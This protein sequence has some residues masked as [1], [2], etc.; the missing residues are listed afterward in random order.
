VTPA[1]LVVRG[2]PVWTGGEAWAEALAIREGTLT[3]VG[4]RDEVAAHLGPDTRVIDLPSD[5]LVLPGFIDAHTH[6][7]TGPLEAAGIDLTEADTLDEVRGILENADRSS[8]VIGGGWRSHIFPDGPDRSLLDEIF[9]TTPVLL[10]EINSHSLWVNSAALAGAG[11]TAA[12]PDPEPGFSMFVHDERGE[13]TGWVL[14]QTAMDLIRN[15]VDPPSPGR[16]REALLAIQREYAA[17]GLTAAFDAGIFMIGERD[18]WE[19]LA[20]L[21]RH[22]LLGQRVVGSKVA[23]IDPDGAVAI[24]AA[25]SAEV[26]SANVRIDT[27]KIFVDGVPE[28]HTAAY[29]E[30]Y[31]DRP[32]TAGPLAADEEQIRRW[33]L[34]ADAAGLSCHMHAIGDRA[35]RVALDAV[36]A[37]RT[38][39]DSGV[40][41]T[42]CHGDLIDPDDLPRFA[43]LGAVWNTSGQ[44]IAMDP[45]YDVMVSRLGD[46]ARRHYL[47]RSAIAAGATVTLGSDYASSSYVST[48]EPLLLIESAATRRLTGV[49]SGEAL[50]PAGEAIPVAEAIRAMTTSAAYQLGIA[51]RTG[52]LEPGKG[53][54]LVVLGRNLFE[55]PAHEIAATPVMVTMRA[56]RITHEAS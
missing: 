27:L 20:D 29:L 19:L 21:D 17:A 11:V 38:R 48:F 2:A 45:V 54:D 56:G 47:L 15:A 25:A 1:D 52:S 14:E 23:N 49:T 13:P 39:G 12:T 8:P 34:E 4:S 37:A 53:A 22:G 46:R 26:R 44:W 42:V 35:V 30:P 7:T 10:R 41:H 9:G 18:G 51:D 16:A 31:S 3:A 33:V 28:A 43:D 24:L 5:H 32:D 40:V 6:Y 36:E 50:P 55:I